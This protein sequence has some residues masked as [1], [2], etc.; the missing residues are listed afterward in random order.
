MLRNELSN[1]YVSYAQLCLAIHYLHL[2]SR[3]Y[4][5]ELQI[6][7]E[8]QCRAIALL[9]RLFYISHLCILYLVSNISHFCHL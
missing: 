3:R 5:F 2:V 8:R 4:K 6:R 7:S 1:G 9:V